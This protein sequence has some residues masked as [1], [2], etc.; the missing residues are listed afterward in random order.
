MNTLIFPTEDISFAQALDGLWKPERVNLD[1]DAL[2]EEMKVRILEDLED[3][4][5]DGRSIITEYWYD[6][7]PFEFSC[8]VEY[9][10]QTIGR[11]TVKPGTT[12]NISDIEIHC[13]WANRDIETNYNIEL[14]KSSIELK[15]FVPK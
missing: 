7:R 14:L 2:A 9:K 8:D 6:K 13:Y 3:L 15:T 12:I 5:D 1:E 4:E 11:G 10:V